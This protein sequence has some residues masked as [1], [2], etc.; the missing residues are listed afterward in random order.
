VTVG[1]GHRPGLFLFV[2]PV[3]AGA[4]VPGMLNKYRENVQ[5]MGYTQGWYD[6]YNTAIRVT[7]ERAWTIPG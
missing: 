6:S 2:A 4:E 3:G 7:P 1:P 5:A